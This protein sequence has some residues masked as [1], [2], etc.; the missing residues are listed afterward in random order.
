MKRLLPVFLLLLVSGPVWAQETRGSIVGT[1]QDSSGAIIA[2]ARV[3]LK[4]VDTNV[5]VEVVTNQKGYYDVPYLVSGAYSVTASAPSF[6]TSERRG[7]VLSAGQRM[8]VDMRLEVGPVAETISI[9]AD[10]PV[11]DTTSATPSTVL[12]TRMV[13]D[14]PVMANSAHLLGRSMP[15]VQVTATQQQLQLHSTM[16]ASYATVGGGI[17]RTEFSVDGAPNQGVGS[18]T[19][20]L[21]STDAI[22]EFRVE[23]AQFD[24]T[25][26]HALGMSMIMVSKG[27]TNEYHGS[28][29]WTHWDRRLN[30]VVSPVNNTY[31]G[32]IKKAEAAGDTAKAAELRAKAKLPGAYENTYA[33]SLGGPLFIPGLVNGKDKL[34]FYAT[35]NGFKSIMTEDFTQAVVNSTVP[36]EAHR[37]GDF[38]DLLALGPQYQ[39]YDPLT[40]RRMPD[41]RI[42]RSPF[43]NNQVPIRN[44][45]YKN[46]VDL[47]PL[48]NP[49][50][51]TTSDGRQNYFAAA[52]PWTWSYWATSGRLDWV[53]TSR[54][55]LF[56]RFSLNDF[57]E[58]RYDY[59]YDV[60]PG[61]N[62]KNYNRHNF[63]AMIDHVFTISSSTILN[64]SI[65]FNR[66]IEG[67]QLKGVQLTYKPSDVG[68]P[69]YMD[70][71]AGQYTALPVIQ[72]AD[73]DNGAAS[74]VDTNHR[75]Y[76]YIGRGYP[77]ASRYSV[78][79]LRSSLMKVAG[80]HSLRLGGE[81]RMNYRTGNG[82]NCSSGCMRFSNQYVREKDNTSNAAN[83]G[84]QWAAFMLGAPDYISYDRNDTV[85]ISNPW[86][87]AYVQDDWRV[88]NKLTLNLGLRYEWEGGMTE[89]YNR[90][91]TTFVPN[92]TLPITTL[93][94]NAYLANPIPGLASINV[95]GGINYA[96]YNGAPRTMNA[97]KGYV[98]PRVGVVL[99]LNDKTVVRA[100][101]GMFSDSFSVLT[102]NGLVDQQYF[103]Q[104]TTTSGSYDTGLTITPNLMTDPFPANRANGLRYDL[105]FTTT[106][107]L[108]SKIGG[109]I[110]RP[111]YDVERA[112]MHKW[113]IGIQRELTKDMSIE[114]AYMGTRTDNFN[115]TQRLNPLS[116]QYFVDS[117]TRNQAWAD[118]LEANVT[119]PFNL[120]NLS[121]LQTT[122]P[123]VYNAIRYNSFFTSP[124]IRKN[125]LLRAYPQY[126]GNVEDVRAPLGKGKYDH[127]EVTINK[128]FSSGIGLLMSYMRA[129]D[130]RKDWFPNE[131]DLDPVWT[132][133]NASRPHTFV[134]NAVVE[135][136][137][138]K[139]KPLLKGGIG[140]VVFGGW[141]VS[142][143]FRWISGGTVGDFGNYYWY[144]PAPANRLD[145]DDPAYKILKVD[146][147]TRTD[148]FNPEPFLL[149]SAT[150]QYPDWKTNPTSYGKVIAAT[151]AA[152]P[153]NYNVRIFPLR[154]DWL[155]NPAN[156]QLDLSVSRTITLTGRTKLQLRLD[157]L[158]ALNQV[159]YGGAT[160]DISSSNFGKVPLSQNNT[161]RWLDF[162]ARLIF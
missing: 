44:P 50:A 40:A 37:R 26:G 76:N 114:V 54:H 138:G 134:A 68:L 12:G 95:V 94:Q 69:T 88:N 99:S 154:F 162:Q 151:N 139:G 3:I 129:W 116:A 108:S 103:S 52:I 155:R 55:K 141:Q 152:R 123:A 43:P 46:Y 91:A 112:R 156:Q 32:A 58:S 23:T 96:G 8:Q 100:G 59:Q 28:G 125:R 42:V 137:F 17:G 122:D 51:N 150:A 5:V 140:N 160:A 107:G 127:I 118:S 36:S 79:T 145:P 30:A 82:P 27:G 45:L 41:G 119:N 117:P 29:T 1:V 74:G 72:F 110:S 66:F 57:I 9:V 61:L 70:E 49:S 144:G 11:L 97:G 85:Y 109:T 146:N 16:G 81:Y 47:L 89:R 62:A 19:A 83:M 121:P 87:A 148:Y 147:Q 48:P 92:A 38:S 86:A 135:L 133:S 64:T 24:A 124:T 113:R 149:P 131:Y 22:S 111:R 20:Y 93:A 106:V 78:A 142:G 126:S 161:A 18:N 90:M 13:L 105:P 73:N 33:G 21:P 25:K 101:W 2:G 35:F 71:M 56:G 77:G 102:D 120:S 104:T 31:W 15:G 63:G 84:L 158:N 75:S 53:A 143:V 39:I 130:K 98:L 80:T 115:L 60:K 159:V 128:R 157:L 136:P 34:F 7:L 153:A 132:I 10:A 4:N 14:L 65:A 67:D 6:K